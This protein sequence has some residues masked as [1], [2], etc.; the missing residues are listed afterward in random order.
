MAVVVALGSRKIAQ[1]NAPP[2]SARTS[3]DALVL[4]AVGVVAAAMSP[5]KGKAKADPAPE[6]SPARDEVLQSDDLVK[7]ILELGGKSV[8]LTRRVYSGGPRTLAFPLVCKAWAKLAKVACEKW[9]VLKRDYRGSEGKLLEYGSPF[10]VLNLRVNSI[11]GAPEA[12]CSD[13]ANTSTLLLGTD[14]SIDLLNVC[15]SISP[16]KMH[17]LFNAGKAHRPNGNG[18]SIP[19]SSRNMEVIYGRFAGMALGPGSKYLYAIHFNLG[20]NATDDSMRTNISTVSVADEKV[21]ST[22]GKRGS[23]D[24]E[25]DLSSF[26]GL[27]H[28]PDRNLLFVSDYRNHRIV[29]LNTSNDSPEVTWAGSTRGSWPFQ[30]NKGGV[31]GELRSPSKLAVHGDF[32]FVLTGA[33][34]KIAVLSLANDTSFGRIVRWIGGNG[35]GMAGSI[36]ALTVHDGRLYVGTRTCVHVL[37]PEGVL[38]QSVRLPDVDRDEAFGNCSMYVD[39]KQVYMMRYNRIEI[40]DIQPSTSA[41][42]SSS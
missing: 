42:G 35:S 40:L 23:G 36:L 30:P 39:D 18:S 3:S 21:V 1:Y 25:F 22:F 41:A 29:F 4:A 5:K 34:D 24:G 20:H 17:K 19:V 33:G 7:I 16:V 26:S 9:Y 28:C 12:W 14:V 2:R 27:A 8:L 37:S 6:P 10:R 11:L 13:S 32:L 31:Y 38:W 15:Q